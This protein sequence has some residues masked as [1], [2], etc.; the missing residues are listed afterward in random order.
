MVKAVVRA[1][2]TLSQLSERRTLP[3]LP[4][5]VHLEKF[6]LVG[7]SKRGMAALQ[8]AAIDDRV[9]AL[10]PAV[11]SIDMDRLEHQLMRS[12]GNP[13]TALFNYFNE[14][15][16][17]RDG[18]L[19]L[20]R[21]YKIVDPV[22]YMQLLTVPK[23]VIH[24]GNDDFFPVDA[25]RSWLA[26]LPGDTSFRM[27]PNSRHL[28]DASGFVPSAISFFRS[29]LQ[30]VEMPKI[31]WSA[32]DDQGTIHVRQLTQ[33]EPLAVRAWRA[34]SCD[35]GKRDFRWDPNS[36]TIRSKCGTWDEANQ[37]W[38]NKRTVWNASSAST[39]GNR[40][41]SA[42]VGQLPPGS[43][44]GAVMIELEFPGPDANGPTVRLTSEVVVSPN[45][46]PFPDCQGQACQGTGLAL[47]Q[48]LANVTAM[49]DVSWRHAVAVSLQR[50]VDIVP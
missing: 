24:A 30:N 13:P 42:S 35:E 21:L 14:R 3:R 33:H 38:V 25:S 4:S 17:S 12:L 46:Y 5:G 10:V 39:T 36:P 1:M 28:M 18:S 44:W 19:E 9:K 47:Q 22:H 8:T 26:Q 37:I 45:T 16:F 31:E 40:S 32:D 41:W 48:V 23:L 15:V 27:V 11:I 50:A 2:D 20:Q 43:G 29:F 6:G 49:S 7:L 34:F